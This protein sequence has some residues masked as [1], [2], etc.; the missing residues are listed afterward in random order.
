MKKEIKVLMVV[1]AT[2][3]KLKRKGLIKVT[4]ELP[5]IRWKGRLIVLWCWLTG[6]SPTAQESI[7]ALNAWQAHCSIKIA[8]MGVVK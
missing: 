1:L 8:K 5:R 2:L 3:H 6:W 7:D 4:G